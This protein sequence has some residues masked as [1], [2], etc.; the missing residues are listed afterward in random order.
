MQYALISLCNLDLGIELCFYDG[1]TDYDALW[2]QFVFPVYI[3]T[4]VSALAIAS[5]YSAK[6]ERLTRKKVIPVIATLILLSYNKIMIV[7]FKGL[8][9]YTTFHFLN[10]Q[11]TTT[12]WEIDTSIALFEAKH[13]LLFTFCSLVFF[14]VIIPINAMLLFTKLFYRFQLVSKYFKPFLDAYQASF[15]DECSFLLGMEFL[16]RAVLYLISYMGKA[17]SGSLYIIIVLLYTAFVCWFHPFKSSLKLFM[18]L[19]YVLYLGIIAVLYLHHS[20]VYVKPS[21]E[22]KITLSLIVYVAFAEFTL[23]IFYHIWRY[24]FCHCVYFKKLENHVLNLNCTAKLKVLY[25]NHYRTRFAN[26]NQDLLSNSEE[27]C[28]YQEELR[29][30]SLD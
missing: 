11:K 19:L 9:S 24:W 21:R 6:I 20:I 18:Y 5:R 17:Y 28:E 26:A 23:I 4:L 12:Y 13:I 7:T 8:F 25:E 2:L 16:L 15:R 22:F 29:M 1:M 10:S 27:Y 3:L 14:L 30:Y